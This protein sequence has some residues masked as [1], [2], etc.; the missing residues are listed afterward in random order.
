LEGYLIAY[1]GGAKLQA[2]TPDFVEVDISLVELHLA[3]VDGL[4]R[5]FLFESLY[6]LAFHVTLTFMRPGIADQI[7]I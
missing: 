5:R 3:L 2:V 7:A 6:L 4:I 1:G